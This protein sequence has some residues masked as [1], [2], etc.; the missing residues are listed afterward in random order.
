MQGFVLLL[1]SGSVSQLARP[2]NNWCS[3]EAIKQCVMCWNCCLCADAHLL[4]LCY[5]VNLLFKD[6]LCRSVSAFMKCS[7]N[8][9]FCFTC[10]LS[11]GS[12]CDKATSIY[13]QCSTASF[14]LLV[15]CKIYNIVQGQFVDL[16]NTSWKAACLSSLH[17]CCITSIPYTEIKQ[18][19]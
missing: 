3:C 8:H 5:P 17:A 16:Q 14:P 1:C 4:C 15:T 2:I 11:R 18:R 13:S 7:R 12:H 9:I 19:N 10:C 6:W